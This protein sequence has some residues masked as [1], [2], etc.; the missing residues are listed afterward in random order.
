MPVNNHRR[1]LTSIFSCILI[2]TIMSGCITENQGTPQPTDSV[3]SPTPVKQA[4]IIFN[5]EV[6]SKTPGGDLVFLDV[7]DE[8]TGLAL[9][10][11]RY[12]MKPI[13]PTHYSIHLPA[14]LGSVIKYR[15]GRDLNPN[16][17]AVEYSAT[18]KQI[19]YRMTYISGPKTI[20]DTVAAWNDILYH[21]QTGRINGQIVDSKTNA[22]VPNVLVD[23]DGSQT[24]TASDGKF[25]MEG[26]MPGTHDLLAY[27][28]DGVYKPYEQLA[29]VEADLMTP[30]PISIES[31]KTVK[32]TFT[33]KPPEGSPRGIPIR[34]VGNILQL[35]NTFADL[36]GGISVVASRAPLMEISPDG[37]Y[38]L[39]LELTSGLDL[40]YKYSL[41]DG[42]WNSEL[43]T[44]GQFQLR[45]LI[46]P[47]NDVTIYDQIQSWQAKDWGP[48]TF[49]VNVNTD[50]PAGD[51]VS[52]Q[53][54]PYGWTEPIPMW[55]LGN[56]KF[57]YILF[58]PLQLL[59]DV[60]YRFCRND[61][62]GIA[63]EDIQSD[64]NK[65]Q[66]FTPQ[67]NP[68]N[69]NI[70]ITKWVSWQASSSPTSLVA[71]Q[72]HKR[73]ANFVAGVELMPKYRPDWVPYFPL[74]FHSIQSI[75]ARWVILTPTWTF[76]SQ[77][78]PVLEPVAGK[79]FIWQD[80]INANSLAGSDG[81]DLAIFPVVDLGSNL[82]N[83]WDTAQKDQ[84]WWQSW[85]DRYQEFILNYADFAQQVKAR[86]LIL[87]D[88]SILPSLPSALA[89]K[90]K[91]SNGSPDADKRWRKLITDVRSR[92]RGQLVW[93]LT[94][95]G[96]V[97]NPPAF[98]DQVD[99]LYV[100]VSAPLGENVK[101][102]FSGFLPQISKILD[103]DIQALKTSLNKPLWIGI[104]YPSI[105]DA[106]KGCADT[107]DGCAAFSL[108]DPPYTEDVPAQIN[109]QEQVDIYHA[110][111][112]A[113]N[114]RSW[115]DG[116]ITRRYFPPVSLQDKSSSVRG[117]PAANV[118]WFWFTQMLQAK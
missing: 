40:R 69:F 101:D 113:I 115:I 83:W 67:S 12:S 70:E 104:D 54:N 18:G 74:A 3:P 2:L 48:I 107:G 23:V 1:F 89:N 78:P 95:P 63:D 72:I 45:Q 34:M 51:S 93:A 47:D 91:P 105:S 99:Q 11:Q 61:Q 19:R 30:A 60:N 32:V 9:N 85:F 44:D 26:L 114:D 112:T 94:S 57:I 14:Q 109:L 31:N 50:T 73:L 41:G 27:S 55:S 15:Y 43:T 52:I 6:P 64:S 66:I 75:G 71:P 59:D 25:L 106:E 56:G 80:L 110:F 62:C 17:P 102:G 5:V 21:G 87:G 36:A 49:N 98:V 111:L 24:L 92:Y 79:D 84:D 42:F 53:F 103:G 81:L 77:N 35:G 76:T 46:V 29:R 38:S 82:I 28:M 16:P 65:N 4:E 116:F 10:P 118:L 37:T 117:K 58:N 88:P 96:N 100:L 33:T 97:S 20:N 86:A 22:P 7:L 8:V 108:L 90:S 39:T 68:Q 13:D